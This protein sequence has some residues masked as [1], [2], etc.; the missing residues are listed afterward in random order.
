MVL[1]VLKRFVCLGGC[2]QY[3]V[4]SLM[5]LSLSSLNSQLST[6]H[7]HS[8]HPSRLSTLQISRLFESSPWL[9]PF[10]HPLGIQSKEWAN[11]YFH[12]FAHVSSSR[13]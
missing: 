3:M 10:G 7:S 4:R 8:P 9:D 13:L 12:S 1:N 6:L 11:F 5:R 2:R